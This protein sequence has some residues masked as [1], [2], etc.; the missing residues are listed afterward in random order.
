[1][2]KVTLP[3]KEIQFL[4]G[5]G[6]LLALD[7]PTQRKAAQYMTEVQEGK[8]YAA[9]LG[10]VNQKR[11]LSANN[12]AWALL[13]LLSEKLNLPAEEI[14][15]NLIRDIGGVSLVY[16]VPEQS[17]DW[18]MEGWRGRGLGWQAEKLDRDGIPGMV[19]VQFWKGSSAYDS[20]QMHR[21]L[22]LIITECQQQGIPTM[23]PEEV[24]RLKGL[25]DEE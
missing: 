20:V 11:S 16:P 2:S 3:V 13:N 10:E 18:L 8:Q 7:A 24:A 15:R 17:A 25:T 5:Y 19:L 9:V 14:Y 23:T 6:V 12:Y 4:P 22:E 21:L 1:M